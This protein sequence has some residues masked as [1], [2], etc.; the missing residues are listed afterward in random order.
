M[1]LSYLPVRKMSYP[2]NMNVDN[3]GI[4]TEL[5]K[6]ANNGQISINI[7]RPGIVR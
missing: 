3:R 6:T 5:V 1:Y 4:F 7:A 2:L